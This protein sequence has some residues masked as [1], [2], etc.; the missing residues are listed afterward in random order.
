[1]T[2]HFGINGARE[3][4]VET[5][6]GL[7]R[8][9]YATVDGALVEN[10]PEK[11]KSFGLIHRALYIEGVDEAA[12]TNG[13]YLVRVPDD[14]AVMKLIGMTG[15]GPSPVFW[16]WAAGEPELVQ[17]L[18]RKAMVRIPPETPEQRPPWDNVLFRHA[19]ANVLAT[20]LEVLTPEQQASFIGKAKAI[21]FFAPDA[22]GLI[23][24]RRPI[25]LPKV[26][27]ETISFTPEQ[28]AQI[29]ENRI[30]RNRRRVMN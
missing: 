4:L 25:D 24:A 9:W 20:M 12:I 8:D 10:L 11:L 28:Y 26:E 6:Q 21:A 23:L 22:L 7:S 1:M 18:R 27:R 5:V 2:I 16:S 14:R 13:P 30:I 15:N 3:D 19:D 17:H 29:E